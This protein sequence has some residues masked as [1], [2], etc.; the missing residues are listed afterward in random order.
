MTVSMAGECIER[1]GPGSAEYYARQLRD[2]LQKEVL[3]ADGGLRGEGRTAAQLLSINEVALARTLLKIPGDA[4]HV[5]QMR[6]IASA[7]RQEWPGVVER[8]AAGERLFVEIA[9][10]ATTVRVLRRDETQVA[11]DD[12]SEVRLLIDL[13]AVI[14]GLFTS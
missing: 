13:R 5:R 14:G 11:A 3:V 1:L 8:V 10:P 12:T 4:I 7:L 9:F 2:L 6:E